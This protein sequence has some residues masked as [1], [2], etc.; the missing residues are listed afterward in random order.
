VKY[1]NAISRAKEIA[2]SKAEITAL[3]PDGA[4]LARDS[5][6]AGEVISI[7]STSMACSFC[8]R[9]TGRKMKTEINQS[10][11]EIRKAES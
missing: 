4:S 11:A 1:E 9:V 6:L 3:V 10:K 2:K 8:H 5:K 7:I